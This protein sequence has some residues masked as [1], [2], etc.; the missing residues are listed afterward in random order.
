MQK[1]QV[2]K[3]MAKDEYLMILFFAA[4]AKKKIVFVN[5]ILNNQIWD[6]DVFDNTFRFEIIMC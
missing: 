1:L 6:H 2:V 3:K 4:H 5:A